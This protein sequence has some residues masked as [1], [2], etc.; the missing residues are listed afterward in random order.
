MKKV[1]ICEKRDAAEELIFSSKFFGDTKTFDRK[2]G[3]YENDKYIFVWCVG[4]LYKQI[5]IDAINESYKLKYKLDSNFDYTMP[6]LINEVVYI[7]DNKENPKQKSSTIWKIKANQLEVIKSILKRTDYDEIIL[8]ADA[9]DEGER[10]HTDP[11][12]YNK[13]LLSR[14]NGN[15]VVITRFWNTGSYKSYDSVKK[16][17][18][19]RKKVNEPKF[20]NR[21]A[22]ANARSMADYFV[23][24][25]MTKAMT[26][27]TETFF[28]CG[29]VISVILGMIGRREDEI[30]NFVPKTYWNIKGTIGKDDNKVDFN[31]YY[32]D[33][34][35]DENGNEIKSKST[36]YFIETEMQDVLDKTKSV[37]Y[38]GKVIKS[39]KR[40]TSSRKP[41]L[42]STDEFNSD[43]MNIY[44]VDL[45]YANA[46]LEWLRDE[47]FTS[48]PRTNGN[49]FHEDDF[50]TIN[51][52]IISSKKYYENELKQLLAND[53]NFDDTKIIL[54]KKNGLFDNKK[55]VT[56]NHV[57]L[58]L[59]KILTASDIQTISK[60]QTHKNRKTANGKPLV[61]T[62]LKEAYD[63]IA[64]RCLIQVLP[65]DIIQKENLTINI[66]S[67]LFEANAEK[68]IYE[69]WRKFDK[70]VTT[71][72]DTVLGI[73]YKEGD[74]IKLD[75]VYSI[76]DKTT[77]P[78][79]Y[80]N[81]TILKA[82]MFVNDALTEEFNSIQDP[83]LK[84]EKMKVFKTVKKMLTTVRGIGT[85]A[86]RE[87][88]LKK[89]EKDGLFVY[90]G[91]GKNIVLTELG[92]YQ[93]ELLP[94]YL[95]S[96]ETTALWEQKLD[97][98]R[99]GLFSY[100]E[101]MEMVNKSIAHM[102]NK[103]MSS[104]I[105]KGNFISATNNNKKPNEKQL[106]LVEMIC[107]TLNIKASKD[108]LKTMSSVSKFIETHKD[109]FSKNFK[110]NVGNAGLPKKL[111]ENQIKFIQN[112]KSNAPKNILDLISK[113]NLSAD[114]YKE[115][116]DFI[117]NS[118]NKMTYKLSEKQDKILNDSKNKD[119]LSKKT[120]E[121][122]KEKQ[123]YNK[124]EYQIIMKDLDKI[125]S[126]FGKK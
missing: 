47:D 42:Y 114:E 27:M 121:L 22:S 79:P 45:D 58:T 14:K 123:E 44:N 8:M 21:L 7:P 6:N 107:K 16:A 76:E 52:A 13:P 1:C 81:K 69:G 30:K 83:N 2:N 110:N 29:R 93:Y 78:K 101:F 62:H 53:N 38:S 19:D 36:R 102:I 82:L 33:I 108:D 115:A 49:Y 63:L 25:I 95:K 10:I 61:L 59:V 126:S 120:I 71:K 96:L 41:K 31:H 18:D 32:D 17:Y 20:K 39:I 43:F 98:I 75:D 105:K 72:K 125:F 3:Y 99:N 40:N 94:D 92:R 87:E 4:H 65:D 50:K 64:T 60:P 117:Q 55:S 116:S 112:P 104:N 57:P 106:K 12:K 100:D 91:K 66:N 37:N 23:G 97:D 51:Q 103:L 48:Y 35:L 88:C 77:V 89:P 118:L 124:E 28:R 67:F 68:M 80:T 34:D 90:E 24:M 122:L 15:P 56:Q 113:D 109:E 54:D 111:S 11:I 84:K 46:C 5:S 26:D 9:D 73:E 70:N 74:S 119:K 85:G 86:T